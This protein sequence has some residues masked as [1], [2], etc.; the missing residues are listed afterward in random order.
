MAVKYSIAQ[1]FRLANNIKY[2]PELGGVLNDALNAKTEIE[3]NS[4]V[5][6]ALT[7]SGAYEVYGHKVKG[8]LGMP[9]Y[10]PVELEDKSSGDTL[11]LENG[12]ISLQ[13]TKNVVVTQLQGR[14][15]S[16]KEFISNGDFAITITGILCERGYGFPKSQVE[17]FNAF[18]EINKALKI[19]NEKAESCG[20]I[21]VVITDYQLPESPWMNCQPY[22]ITALSDEPF[23]NRPEI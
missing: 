16:A 18:M 22:T 2:S 23:V 5:Q 11:L 17:D 6:D 3:Y 1:L 8:D 7:L 13:R 9:L 19:Y 12:I 14:T 21:E 20:I 15:S 10:M 4:A